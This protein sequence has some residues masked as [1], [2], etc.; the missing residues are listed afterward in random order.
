MSML[1]DRNGSSPRAAASERTE[2]AYPTFLH[3]IR[4]LIAAR[5]QNVQ[6]TFMHNAKLYDLRAASSAADGMKL[7]TGRIVE[8]VTEQAARSEPNFRVWS[9]PND[10]SGLPT[11]IEFRPRSFLRLVFEHDPAA[12]GPILRCLIPEE[13]T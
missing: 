11:R 5:R 3:A 4:S 6:C 12:A 9:H 8:Q 13:K 1:R 10:P 2:H 7:L